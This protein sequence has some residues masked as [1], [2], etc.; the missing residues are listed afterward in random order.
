MLNDDNSTRMYF[1]VPPHYKFACL[2]LLAYCSFDAVA[3]TVM[4]VGSFLLPSLLQ[5][6]SDG[7]GTLYGMIFSNAHA[8]TGGFAANARR[9]SVTP[10]QNSA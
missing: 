1:R 10:K 3:D 4:V 5:L 9:I 7:G 8:D 2:G 6:E